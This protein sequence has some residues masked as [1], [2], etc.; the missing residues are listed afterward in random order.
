MKTWWHYRLVR[1]G[2]FWATS[3]GLLFVVQLPAHFLIDTKLYGWGLLLN[4]LPVSMLATYVLL[5]W[6]LPR[7]LQGQVLAFV[8]LLAGWVAA[9]LLL[10]NTTQ[11]FYTFV[12]AP[13]LFGGTPGRAFSWQEYHVS[14]PTWF[15]LLV[16]AGGA[17]AIKVMNGWYEQRQLQEALL[18]RRMHTELQLL[19]AQL[20]PTFLFDTLH[21]LRRLTTEKAP[22]APEAVLHLSALLRY[23]LYESPQTSVPLANEVAMM[24]HYVALEQLRLGP[25]IEVSVSFSGELEGHSVAPLLLLPLLEN[26]FRHGTGPALDC[27]WISIDL[28]ARKNLLIFKLINSWG[29]AAAGWRE[30]H[31]LRTI[32]QRL[33]RLYPGRH[34]LKILTDADTFL[35]VLELQP[36]PLPATA[37]LVAAPSSQRAAYPASMLPS[38]N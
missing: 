24:R 14:S 25:R 2:L 18:E 9:T 5:Y 6:L 36:H 23:L 26:A 31:G 20:Q 19:R 33:A 30:G 38:G 8:G 1:H 29:E 21:V 34:A 11:A 12:L 37:A 22:T 16:T 27:P 17:C 4:Q 10:A 32:R 3:T 7:L 28:V 35:V 13:A 15:Q